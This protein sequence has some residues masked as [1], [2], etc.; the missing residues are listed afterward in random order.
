MAA[1]L[2]PGSRV[3]GLDPRSARPDPLAE[4]RGAVGHEAVD[5]E[6]EE[7]LHR[8]A[9]VDR[10]DVDGQAEIMGRGDH[11]AIDERQAAATERDLD[12]AATTAADAGEEPSPAG[13]R[14]EPE[15]G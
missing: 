14:R 1:I 7:A 10:P 3:R 8:R 9:V 2:G 5:P 13:Q 15:R 6:V 12:A 11:P 4:E